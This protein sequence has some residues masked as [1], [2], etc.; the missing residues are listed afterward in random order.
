MKIFISISVKQTQ[1]IAK[2]IIKKNINKI[3]HIIFLL[4]GELGSG[5]TQFVKGIASGLGIDTKKVHSPSFVF[6]TDIVKKDV[7]LYHIDFYRIQQQFV[8]KIF[9]DH[10]EEIFCLK[11]KKT[12]TCI[13]WADKI[14]NLVIKQLSDLTKKS[15]INII[16]INF[17]I[18]KNFLRKITICKF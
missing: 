7:V 2:S 15:D 9:Y 10:L 14:S 6:I 13:E 16:E 5:K 1:S 8:H 17:V 18:L 3:Q 12:V 4:S 11:T